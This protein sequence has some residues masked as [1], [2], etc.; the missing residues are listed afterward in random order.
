MQAHLFEFALHPH[1]LL[2]EPKYKSLNPTVVSAIM[3][4][5]ACR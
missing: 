5:I 4:V 1:Y 3:G 2:I